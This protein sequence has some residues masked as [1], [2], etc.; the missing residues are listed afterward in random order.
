V[1]GALQALVVNDGTKVQERA[2]DRRAGASVVL[3]SLLGFETSRQVHV[4]AGAAVTAARCGHVDEGAR[5]GPEVPERRGGSV[6]QDGLGSAREDGR[7]PMAVG[8]QHAMPDRV[9][10]VMQRMQGSSREP[11]G[12]LLRA[13]IDI[14]ELR[15]DYDTMLRPGQAGEGPVQRNWL[16]L[17]PPSVVNSNQ[18]GDDDHRGDVLS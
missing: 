3:R 11:V 14:E 15:S 1:P 4:D 2:R 9:H 18:F 13:E 7:E 10:T 16:R 17:C 5:S 8:R 12:D 6:A